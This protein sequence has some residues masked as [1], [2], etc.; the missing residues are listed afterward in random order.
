[1]G[2]NGCRVE[3]M[4]RMRKNETEEGNVGT[5]IKWKGKI[6]GEEIGYILLQEG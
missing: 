6:R 1:M 2:I 5:F 3:R 4:T